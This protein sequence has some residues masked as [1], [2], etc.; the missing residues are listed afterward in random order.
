MKSY[1]KDYALQ[2]YKL[3][4]QPFPIQPG[5]KIPF[6]N[7]G[8]SW[9]CDIDESRIK[10]WAENGRGAGGIGLH[11][12]SAIDCDI[13]DKFI[14]KAVLTA[15]KNTVP[16][17]KFLFRVGESPKFLVP[18]HRNSC[19]TKKRKISYYY[20]DGRK[21]EIELLPAGSHYFVSY[22]MHP[23]GAEYT[24]FV[25]SP[26]DMPAENLFEIDEIDIAVIEDAFDKACIA[27]GLSANKPDMSPQQQLLLTT[28]GES[29]HPLSEIKLPEGLSIDEIKRYLDDLPAM[30]CDD[31][32]SWIKTGAAIHH[33]TMG[34]DSGYHLFDSWSQQSPKYKGTQDT[35][36][37]W[38]SFSAAKTGRN[39]AT[40]RS[41]IT[42]AKQAQAIESVEVEQIPFDVLVSKD[43]AYHKAIHDAS[44][45]AD[46]RAVITDLRRDIK[47]DNLM[48]SDLVGK[49]QK[50]AK[51]I[52]I[53]WRVSD[54]RSD[55]RPKVRTCGLPTG[56]K[57]PDWVKDWV[58]LI[59]QD[60]FALP[61]G[62][63]QY[64]R[65]GFRG[66]YGREMD[67]MAEISGE[68]YIDPDIYALNK[69]RIMTVHDV[70]YFPGAGAD[71]FTFEGNLYLNLYSKDSRGEQK[72]RSEWTQADKEA[73][74]KFRD[75][76][77]QMFHLDGE[78]RLMLD[79][80]A[81][82]CQKG[83][84]QRLE[85]MLIIKGCEGDGKTVVM[86]ACAGCVGEKNTGVINAEEMID[87]HFTDWA[88]GH[89][90]KQVE[91]LKMPDKNRYATL[92]KLK[93][94]I[95]NRVVSIHPK[96]RRAYK[97]INTA[98]YIA[99]TNFFDCL[100]LSDDSRRFT[101]IQSRW[102]SKDALTHQLGGQYFSELFRAIDEH[103]SA[104]NEFLMTWEISPGFSPFD[105]PATQTR[106]EVI[107]LNA[108]EAALTIND[109]VETGN[110]NN[111]NKMLVDTKAL[112]DLLEL[113]YDLS[114]PPR[115]LSDAL[116]S[117]GYKRI[118]WQVKINQS[119]RR[120]YTTTINV[121]SSRK[122]VNQQI[123]NILELPF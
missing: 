2:L 123:R 56:D 122:D 84:K 105:A 37:R 28:R 45:Q 88:S 3:G 108:S 7:Q 47:L 1:Y 95:T 10:S 46:L 72:P 55:I 74:Q 99:T 71:T 67:T 31:R 9:Q 42:A 41:I 22:G 40:I 109:I 119:P 110:Y 103:S 16:D 111:I 86:N 61:G 121:T 70:M 35:R 93:P 87:H 11:Q 14:S 107:L 43:N 6:L 64:T 80:M 89:I 118:P 23:C 50:K 82:I 52:G 53:T 91:E 85:W 94:Y 106:K 5:L 90:F 101:M 44:S 113:E 116:Q 63:N 34:S 100:P 36:G 62:D 19:I 21:E 66:L 48:I 92:N 117:L 33:E 29:L 96:G 18:L 78:A 77:E 39:A 104:V 58:Y 12:L 65:S 76:I 57:A 15:I 97:G 38:D 51:T 75:H 13:K 20:N 32:D 120:F 69:A 114:L 8:E 68:P 49:I 26:L 102:R 54:I 83:D 81:Y 27:Q 25:K 60:K 24:W 17:D 79:T 4:Y 59:N 30:M 112:N 73:V 115:N 98:S